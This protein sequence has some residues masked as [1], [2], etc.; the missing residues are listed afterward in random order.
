MKTLFLLNPKSGTGSRDAIIAQLTAFCTN[1]SAAS[2]WEFCGSREELLPTIERA[3]AGGFEVIAAVGGDGT[4][5]EIGRRLAGSG[6][7]LAI[8]PTGSGNGLARHLQ[9]P[10]N[11]GGALEVLRSGVTLKADVA[12]VNQ[13]RFLSVAGVG[14]DAM[15]AT[16][17]EQSGQRGLSSY[18]RQS[19]EALISY[20][21]ERYRITID[22]QP[23]FDGQA[24]LVAVANST[25]Y[26]NDA[27]I[28]P[29]ASLTDGLLDLCIL[30]KA[31]MTELASTVVRLFRGE[32]HHSSFLR[33]RKGRHIIIERE[34]EGAAH[35]DGEPAMLPALLDFRVV[36]NALDLVV[37]ASLARSG[38]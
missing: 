10:L 28:A 31:P 27:R 19:V 35:V 9:I 32:L 3:R 14:F 22:G 4:V 25:Q 18:A 13:I 20:R 21:R 34:R 17:F 12:S 38:V 6:I 7:A 2:A 1:D 29:L 24:F 37:P 11:V 16:R 5:S 33:I 36:E 15:V 30:E 8:V 23:A 26:G